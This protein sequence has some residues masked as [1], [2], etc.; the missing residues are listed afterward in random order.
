M[1][2]CGGHLRMCDV[3][4]Y[5]MKVFVPLICYN[6]TANTEWMM[7]VFRLI[8]FFKENN[9]NAT[10]YPITFESLIS[11]ARNAAVAHFMSDPDATHLLFIDSDIE[12]TPEDV[13]KLF[14]INQ[15]VVAASYPQ[16]WLDEN[17]IKMV[18]SASEL[19]KQP[20][21]LCTKLP[22]HFLPN[23]QVSPVME[24]EY[25]ATG[26]LLI[27]KG[28][29][30]TMM[31]KYPERQYINDIDGY[32]SCDPNMF[33][34]FFPVHIHSATRKY[35][36]EDYGFSRL[37]REAGGKIW[38]ATDVTLTHRGWFGFSANAFRQMSLNI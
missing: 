27:Q 11:R 36:S 38:I 23:Q 24:A 3:Y 35:E 12:F 37:W 21:S 19:P 30:Q 6:H 14:Q 33:Y 15:P 4:F 34:D 2:D 18:F 10:I 9:I 31:Q 8:M 5:I 20:L 28:V 26:F 29:F 16:K 13:I 7:C 17:K 25:V 1:E 32:M 22:V